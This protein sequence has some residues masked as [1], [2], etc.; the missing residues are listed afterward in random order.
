M[1]EY[2]SMMLEE[3]SQSLRIFTTK[4]LTI[5]QAAR[6]INCSETFIQVNAKKGYLQSYLGS[7]GLLF[8][9]KDLQNFIVSYTERIRNK[10]KMKKDSE[11]NDCE[12]EQQPVEEP[13]KDEC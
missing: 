4:F 10:N 9:K 11:S 2:N 12:S 5:T 13:I 6:Y 7:R 8:Q 1:D 3:I